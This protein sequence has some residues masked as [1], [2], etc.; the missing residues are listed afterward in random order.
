MKISRITPTGRVG[1]PIAEIDSAQH[2]AISDQTL[3]LRGADRNDRGVEVAIDLSELVNLLGAIP[4]GRF[5]DAGLSPAQVADLMVTV[6]QLGQPRPANAG[7][8]AID[9]DDENTEAHQRPGLTSSD[10][11]DET[12]HY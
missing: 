7:E 12:P 8:T 9:H 4:H 10:D 3:R 11:D 1:T 5:R 6:E 2:G